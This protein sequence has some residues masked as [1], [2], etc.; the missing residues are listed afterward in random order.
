MDLLHA[1]P[2]P[3]GKANGIMSEFSGVRNVSLRTFLTTNDTYSRII[4]GKPY[5]ATDEQI[6]LSAQLAKEIL[7]TGKLDNKYCFYFLITNPFV[8]I[9]SLNYENYSNIKLGNPLFSSYKVTGNLNGWQNT[10]CGDLV[11]KI[12]EKTKISNL[13]QINIFGFKK[14]RSSTFYENYR[15]NKSISFIMSWGEN[16]NEMRKY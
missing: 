1:T 7:E 16:P 14:Y 12:Y 13:P 6:T 4:I 8:F 9:K 3:I 5:H 10:Y 15:K 2:P 11:G